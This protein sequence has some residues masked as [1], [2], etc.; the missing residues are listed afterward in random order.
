MKKF[1]HSLVLALKETWDLG[2]RG[3]RARGL[4]DSVE[5]S[6]ID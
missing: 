3:T 5:S 4:S 6:W 2:A 1:V